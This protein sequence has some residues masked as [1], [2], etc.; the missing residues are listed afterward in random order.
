MT[1]HTGGRA[2]DGRR[3][4][5]SSMGKQSGGRES[6]GFIKLC[7]GKSLPAQHQPASIVSGLMTNFAGRLP[8]LLGGQEQVQRKDHGAHGEKRQGQNELAGQEARGGDSGSSGRKFLTID[9]MSGSGRGD[10]GGSFHRDF[11]STV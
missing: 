3:S 9:E 6:A 2:V 5:A 4:G 8:V 7:L 11:I 10:G 1:N